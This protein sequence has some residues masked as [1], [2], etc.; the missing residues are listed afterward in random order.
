[1]SEFSDL[2]SE[3][4]RQPREKYINVLTGSYEI[5]K[6]PTE[7]YDEVIFKIQRALDP[8][9]TSEHMLIDLDRLYQFAVVINS[10]NPDK[11]IKHDINKRP[12]KAIISS[13]GEKL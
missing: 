2:F 3:R 12:F 5:S 1:M 9:E 8:G 11:R 13:K 4:R 6:H 10:K 7:E